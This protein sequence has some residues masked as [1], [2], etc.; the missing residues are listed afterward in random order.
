VNNPFP[1]PESPVQHW[2]WHSNRIPGWLTDSEACQLYTL[3]R[4]IPPELTPTVVELGSWQGKSSVMIAGGLAGRPGARL[5]CVDPFGRDENPE[6]QR[7]YYDHLVS[8]MERSLEQAFSDHMRQ[9][10]VS[11][12]T[13]AI[14]GYSFEV[15]QTWTRPIDF[16]FIDANHEYEAVQRDFEQ[17]EPFVRIGG[18]VALHD[19]SP[20]WPGPTRVRDERFQLPKFDTFSQVD[21]LVWAVKTA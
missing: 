7:L 18:I 3:A 16:L 20:S 10:G 8:S 13:E 6:Y 17:W 21:S 9:S 15:V 5:Y 14:K 1:P 4:D 12:I 2:L 19:V 11:S